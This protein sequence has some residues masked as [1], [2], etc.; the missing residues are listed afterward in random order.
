VKANYVEFL[1][2]KSILIGA[3]AWLLVLLIFQR[4]ASGSY[5]LWLLIA[6]YVLAISP[7]YFTPRASALPEL[8]GVL[9]LAAALAASAAWGGAGKRRGAKASGGGLDPAIA[10]VL[11]F[12][13]CLLGVGYNAWREA[14]VVRQ[15]RERGTAL[16]A[17]NKAALDAT[18]GKRKELWGPL[19]LTAWPGTAPSDLPGATSSR[20][21]LDDPALAPLIDTLIPRYSAD[22]VLR[23][24]TPL[25]AILLWPDLS[26][27]DAKLAD[28]LRE[29]WIW[30]EEF[31]DVQGARLWSRGP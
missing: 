16:A 6:G 2:R 20:M 29:S 27:S 7:T 26:E 8:C 28:T 21:W 18:A 17:A 19:D 10:G 15:W 4:L 1:T 13:L 22:E 3:G 31:V 9:L 24:E 12:V 25:R 11:I 30:R 23:G 5:W 14:G